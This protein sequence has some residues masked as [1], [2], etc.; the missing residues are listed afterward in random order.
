M[1][2][3]LRTE[4]RSDGFICV[5]DPS[6]RHCF[7]H[8]RISLWGASRWLDSRRKPCCE[9]HSACALPHSPT[10]HG[11]LDYKV[12]AAFQVHVYSHPLLP[13]YA[14]KISKC[15]NIS[16]FPPSLVWLLRCQGD[17]FASRKPAANNECF[18]YPHFKLKFIFR[19]A[20]KVIRRK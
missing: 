9:L 16:I 12:Y 4:W 17:K 14:I 10:L 15:F 8:R 6:S 5:T 1:F 2:L 19:Q 3:G 11:K 18:R 20:W 13:L 7:N